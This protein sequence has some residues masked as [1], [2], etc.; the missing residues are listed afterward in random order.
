MR[1]D[2][3]PEF[4]FAALGYGVNTVARADACLAVVACLGHV[5]FLSFCCCFW[6][7]ARHATLP[8]WRAAVCKRKGE[9]EK[10]RLR[11]LLL[12]IQKSQKNETKICAGLSLERADG[13]AL[14]SGA[15][16][17]ATRQGPR[18]RGPVHPS[19]SLEIFA[20]A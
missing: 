6:L 9:S 7:H 20:G 5:I 16:S 18:L 1:A 15:G 3:T 12:K 17:G 19:S 2:R 13:G 4:A 10:F 14:S 8:S 11:F